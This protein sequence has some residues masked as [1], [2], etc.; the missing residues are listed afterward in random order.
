M[1]DLGAFG[2]SEVTLVAAALRRLGKGVSSLEQASQRVAR[3]FHDEFVDSSTGRSAVV[4]ARCYK[5]HPLGD[6]PADVA[7]FARGVFPDQVLDVDTQCLTLLGTFGD[8]PLW[9]SR[10]ASRG[11]QAIPL[12][13]ERTLESLPMVARL[14]HALGL[15]A[16]EVVHPNAAFLLEKDRQGFNVFHVEEAMGSPYIPAQESFVQPFGV[17]SVVGFGFVFPPT[18]V[19]ATI[20]FSRQHIAAE[21]ADLFK[22]LALSLKLAL[23]PLASG[24]VF[25][26]TRA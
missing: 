13:N 25:D 12:A 3:F 2:L 23:L 4:L 7:T 18:H 16:R 26:E 9:Q 10:I 14:T 20:L 22:T 5:T 17:R 1:Y 8:D 21:T 15:E 19:F 24:R 6:L 11:H